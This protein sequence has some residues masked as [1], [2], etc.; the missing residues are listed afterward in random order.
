MWCDRRFI[1]KLFNVQIPKG[2]AGKELTAEYQCFV[3]GFLIGCDFES[4]SWGDFLDFRKEFPLKTSH[5]QTF[6][7]KQKEDN[8]WAVL[9]NHE[10]ATRLAYFEHGI[11]K[12]DWEPLE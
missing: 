9:E 5:W 4:K 2:K 8:L 11:R 3:R 1:R 10:G 7:Q 6:F 12:T